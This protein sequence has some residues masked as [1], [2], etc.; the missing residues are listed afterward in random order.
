MSFVP[1]RLQLDLAE[2]QPVYEQQDVRPTVLLADFINRNWL[3]ARKSL[4]SGASRSRRASPENGLL[5]AAVLSTVTGTPSTRSS[6]KA[7]WSRIGSGDAVSRTRSTASDRSLGA[8]PPGSARPAQRAAALPGRPHPTSTAP[9]RDA[10]RC[11]LRS[12]RVPPTKPAQP[13]KRRLLGIRVQAGTGRPFR[14]SQ[15]AAGS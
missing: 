15:R 3:T 13:L 6:W 4:N 11:D 1:R 7:R 10:V 2:R 5:L 9:V 8:A 12:V 14:R